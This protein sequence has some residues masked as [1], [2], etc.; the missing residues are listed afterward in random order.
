ML[1]AEVVERKMPQLLRE[2]RERLLLPALGF[3][4]LD[5]A[6]E[7]RAVDDG[8]EQ[9]VALVPPAPEGHGLELV[10][11]E[12]E[13]VCM[14]CHATR[15]KAPCIAQARARVGWRRSVGGQR[16]SESESEWQ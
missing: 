1:T 2:R 5:E 9:S 4:A 7:A 3:L 13:V 10:G 15:G 16:A 14:P 12:L 6:L 8:L 11:Q